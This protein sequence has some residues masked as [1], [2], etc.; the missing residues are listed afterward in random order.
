M[1][2]ASV[3]GATINPLPYYLVL[4]SNQTVRD[5]LV[6]PRLHEESEARR[7]KDLSSITQL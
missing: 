2:K 4:P 1:S 5:V 3:P 7:G 6:S